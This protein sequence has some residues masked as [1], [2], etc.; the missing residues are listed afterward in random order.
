MSELA[1][2]R[3]Q[4][5]AADDRIFDAVAQ[6]YA[7]IRAIAEYKRVHGVPMNHPARI[8]HVRER[9]RKFAAM[10]RID[11]D[12]LDRVAIELIGAACE[13]ETMLMAGGSQAGETAD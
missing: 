7:V 10:I 12:R 8:D 1:S 2:L 9:Y 11:A 4:L 5:D 13:L 3:E 6:R